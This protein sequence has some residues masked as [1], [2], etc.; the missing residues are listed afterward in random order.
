MSN[1]AFSVLFEEELED[2][3]GDDDDDDD[4]GGGDGG[5]TWKLMRTRAM[6]DVCKGEGCMPR[7]SRPVVVS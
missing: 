6:W 1:S 5:A 4:G 2:D 3:D 7:Q